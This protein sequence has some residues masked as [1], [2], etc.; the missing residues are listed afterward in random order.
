MASVD[1]ERKILELF[2]YNH[3]LKFSDIEKS[4]NLRSNKVAYHIKQLLNKK[5]LSKINDTY[6]LSESSEYLIPYISD[7]KNPLPVI[8]I[9]IG[10]NKKCFLIKRNKKP[11]KDKLSLPGGR[12]LL[13]E[14]IE[15]GT[16]RLMKEKWNLNVKL[17]KVNSISLEHV[18]KN[19]KIIHSF[20]LIFV[21]AKENSYNEL[22]KI[23]LVNILKNKKNIITSDYSLINKDLNKKI[24]INTISTLN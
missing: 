24:N 2:L 3:K 19:K 10:N 9:H 14:S 1:I 5:I 13:G 23:N 17:K 20:L 8:L 18:L 22:N 15:N 12:L 11:F 6:L 21:S 7:K 4:L 16:K